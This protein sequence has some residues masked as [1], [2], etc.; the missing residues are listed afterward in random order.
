MPIDLERRCTKYVKKELAGVRPVS[1]QLG[2]HRTEFLG[3]SN[4]R[5]ECGVLL[6]R[7]SEAILGKCLYKKTWFRDYESPRK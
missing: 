6:I 5:S 2:L 1:L 4:S 3:I 7:F